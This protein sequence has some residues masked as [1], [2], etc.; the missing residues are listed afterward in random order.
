MEEVIKINIMPADFKRYNDREPEDAME[1]RIYAGKVREFIENAINEVRPRMVTAV[2][3][4]TDKPW[5]MNKK[6]AAQAAEIKRLRKAC[7]IGLE[8]MARW[9]SQD[10]CDCPAEGH[11]CGIPRL[12]RNIKEV[13]QALKPQERSET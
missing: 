10:E 8:E 6:L 11:I 13:E 1:L 7:K 3:I 12:R 2:W 9:E 5:G 4:E